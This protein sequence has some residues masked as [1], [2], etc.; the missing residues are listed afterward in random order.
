MYQWLKNILLSSA[1]LHTLSKLYDVPVDFVAPLPSFEVMYCFI[2]GRRR[3]AVALYR[4]ICLAL[5]H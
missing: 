4:M 3:V 2:F 5:A 1:P